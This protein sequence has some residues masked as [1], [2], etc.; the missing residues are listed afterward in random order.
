MSNKSLQVLHRGIDAWSSAYYPN[1]R[2]RPLVF[3]GPVHGMA[4][5]DAMNLLGL[6]SFSMA[7]TAPKTDSTWYRFNK[8]LFRG[9]TLHS[10]TIRTENTRRTYLLHNWNTSKHIPL[11]PTKTRYTS[12]ERISISLDKSA[13]HPLYVQKRV[14]RLCFLL[15]IYLRMRQMES[16]TNTA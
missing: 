11:P 2:F 4:Y 14:H 1:P 15:S 10:I 3:D 13:A 7:V 6:R 16:N 8:R 5:L 9:E 12:R